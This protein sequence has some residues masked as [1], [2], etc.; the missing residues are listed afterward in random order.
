MLL[1]P[2]FVVLGYWVTKVSSKVS[3]KTYE[4]EA[5]VEKM[6][7]NLW[8]FLLERLRGRSPTVPP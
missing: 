7:A 2:R 3:S 6:P 5:P 8:I 1:Y 4:R